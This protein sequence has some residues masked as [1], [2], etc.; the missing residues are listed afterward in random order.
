[1]AGSAQRGDVVGRVG[2]HPRSGARPG[3]PPVNRGRR[4]ELCGH[5]APRRRRR[6]APPTS[7]RHSG[8]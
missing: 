2:R 7:V 5:R 1:L 3:R 4:R 8:T 6:A